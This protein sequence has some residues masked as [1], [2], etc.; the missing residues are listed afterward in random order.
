MIIYENSRLFSLCELEISYQTGIKLV[1]DKANFR[2]NGC[3]VKLKQ[4]LS[5]RVGKP[6]SFCFRPGCFTPDKVSCFFI[7]FGGFK[8]KLLNQKKS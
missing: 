4:G 5:G 6:L 8:K 7:G 2:R 3:E 1:A